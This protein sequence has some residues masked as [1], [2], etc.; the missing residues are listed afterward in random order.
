MLVRMLVT[1]RWL[2]VF[3]RRTRELHGSHQ[4][5]W[6]LVEPDGLGQGPASGAL[7]RPGGSQVFGRL[8]ARLGRLGDR[9][10]RRLLGCRLR[11]LPRAGDI[12]DRPPRSGRRGVDDRGAR[13]RWT[14]IARSS[15]ASF[16]RRTAIGRTSESPFARGRTTI[17]RRPEAPLART[18][19]ARRS[20]PA[21]T[22]GWTAIARRSKPS[23]TGWT[24][25]A[26]RSEPSFT[27]RAAIA[28]RPEPAL[29][30]TTIA[31]RSEPALAR[32][33]P[34]TRRAIPRGSL[35]SARAS[36]LVVFRHR[37]P[38]FRAARRIRTAA[39]AAPKPLSMF[40]TVMPDA[41]LVSMPRS[42]ESP[43]KLAP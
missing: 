21:L 41:Q 26:R 39:N 37:V 38:T 22:R 35:A 31:R 23:F 30:R 7:G 20:E 15:E 17:A 32:G 16:A 1:L 4:S 14:T 33:R 2:L 29:A 9:R 12:A 19:I 42:A 13:R 28:R 5:D 10:R 6:G 8:L 27:G 3:Y 25:I 43:W 18:T 34:A 11:H 36:L 40:T 24:A